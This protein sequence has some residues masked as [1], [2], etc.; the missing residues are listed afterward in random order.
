[1]A[2]VT[3][4]KLWKSADDHRGGSICNEILTVSYILESFG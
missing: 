1:M 3:L 2:F 4:A